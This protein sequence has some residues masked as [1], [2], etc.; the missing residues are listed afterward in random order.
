MNEG[1]LVFSTGKRSMG[2]GLSMKTPGLWLWLWGGWLHSCAL[3]SI[4]SWASLGS[5]AFLMTSENSG[6]FAYASNYKKR[7]RSCPHGQNT[8][9]D[10]CTFLARVATFSSLTVFAFLSVKKG[11]KDTKPGRMC[12]LESGCCGFLPLG[13]GVWEF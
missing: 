8:A 13:H 5:S 2:P 3:L 10:K 1:T 12:P 6:H 4:P 11:Q 9:P 7:V